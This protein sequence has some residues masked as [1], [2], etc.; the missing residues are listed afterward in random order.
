MS[1]SRDF[2]QAGPCQRGAQWYFGEP[3]QKDMTF[4]V[5]SLFFFAFKKACMLACYILRQHFLS[6]CPK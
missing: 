5:L 3:E 1:Y 6:C 2:K 4:Q